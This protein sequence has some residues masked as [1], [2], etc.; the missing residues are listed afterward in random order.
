[1]RL[2]IE[3][4][5]TDKDSRIRGADEMK[6]KVRKAV[7]N[8]VEILAEKYQPEKIILFGSNVYGKPTE[9]SDI[10]LLI[11]KETDKPFYKR[12]SEVCTLVSDIIKT[13][14]FS[15]FV[16]TPAELKERLERGDQFFEEIIKKGEVLHG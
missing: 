13:V 8:I 3:R 12:W 4:E 11:V 15:P 6:T 9:E 1:M 2:S 14:P 10:D 16:V 7:E 5:W